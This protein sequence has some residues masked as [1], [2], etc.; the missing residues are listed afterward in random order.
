M[1]PLEDVVCVS[2]VRTPMGN[3]GGTLRNMPVYDLGAVAMREALARAKVAPTDVTE[4]I[5][6]NTR[7]AGNGPNPGRTAAL[8]AG[9]PVSVH[10]LTINNA[11]P[12]SMKGIIIA[13][14]MIRCQDADIV[15]ISP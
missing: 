9:V 15:L 4:V 6:G 1:I 11:C 13:S 7:Q 5:V 10:V 8:R 14:Q 12:S 3:F 2:A